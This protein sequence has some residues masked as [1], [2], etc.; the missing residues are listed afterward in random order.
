MDGATARAN[1]MQRK[2]GDSDWQRL[3]HL[4]VYGLLHRPA[5]IRARVPVPELNG[6]NYSARLGSPACNPDVHPTAQPFVCERIINSRPAWRGWG[7][8]RVYAPRQLRRRC[9]CTRRLS[10][11]EGAAAPPPITTGTTGAAA[12]AAA[13]AAAPSPKYLWWTM[14]PKCQRPVRPIVKLTANRL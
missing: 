8:C 3:A 13:A 14:R 5:P 7:K 1:R 11:E 12:V 4:A 9:Y 2:G 6:N 10:D